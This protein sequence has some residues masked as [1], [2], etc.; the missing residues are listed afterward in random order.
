MENCLAIE[1]YEVIVRESYLQMARSKEDEAYFS[2]TR[3][4]RVSRQWMDRPNEKCFRV[5]RQFGSCDDTKTSP[6]YQAIH[7]QNPRYLF[8]QFEKGKRLLKRRRSRF[9]S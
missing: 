8:D 2:P 1:N 5:V 9:S 4:S 6:V 7:P 3:I